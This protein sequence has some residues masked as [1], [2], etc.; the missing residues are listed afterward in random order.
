M[1]NCIYCG[2]PVTFWQWLTRQS[3]K[4][5]EHSPAV[6]HIT[7]KVEPKAGT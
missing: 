3:Y 1:A 6:A 7:C 4:P 5:S 2:R